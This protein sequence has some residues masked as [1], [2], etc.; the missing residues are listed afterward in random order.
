MMYQFLKD[1]SKDVYTEDKDTKTGWGTP[2]L[3]DPATIDVV[4]YGGEM[5]NSRNID[6]LRAD[7]AA[8]CHKFVELCKAAGYPVLVT[9]TVRD[10]A[11]QEYCYYKGTSSSPVPSFHSVAAGLAFDI[12]KNVKGE[13]YS[14]S[15]FWTGVGAIGQKMGFNWGGAWTDFVDKPHFQWSNHGKYTSNMIRAGNYPPAMPLYE[16]EKPVTVTEGKTILKEKA[17]L[18]EATIEFLYNYRYGDSLIIKLATA[19]NQ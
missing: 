10:N 12:C 14:D 16:E 11:Y 4:K 7:V 2:I 13:E 17:G 9:G 8:N 19:M 1:C 15:T 6:H 18:S 3:P 5:L